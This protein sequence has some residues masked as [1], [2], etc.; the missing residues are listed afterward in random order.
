[1]CVVHFFG[2]RT[3]LPGH[4]VP[5]ENP[6]EAVFGSPGSCF[7]LFLYQPM[8]RESAG[9]NAMLQS[10]QNQLTVI[11]NQ[12]DAFVEMEQAKAAHSLH[13]THRAF[14]GLRKQPSQTALRE[15]CSSLLSALRTASGDAHGCLTGS[16]VRGTLCSEPSYQTMTVSRSADVLPAAIWASL[17]VRRELGA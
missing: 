10:I 9:G 5:D 8:L 2:D 4:D 14:H 11:E 7:T 1:M 16:I 15:R 6:A 17:V 12:V 3:D 13:R